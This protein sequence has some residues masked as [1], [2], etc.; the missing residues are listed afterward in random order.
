MAAPAVRVGVLV[1]DVPE[2]QSAGLE[3]G[4]EL[5]VGILEEGAAGLGQLVRAMKFTV[6]AKAVKIEF[7]GGRLPP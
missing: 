1:G 3:V 4:D 7:D 6:D 5:L 2:Q